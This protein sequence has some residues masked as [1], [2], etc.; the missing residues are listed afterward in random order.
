MRT[1]LA[2]VAVVLVLAAAVVG[3]DGLGGWLAVLAGGAVA[4]LAVVEEVARL[5]GWL[6]AL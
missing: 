4:G 6:T 3:Q 2:V 5:R 1:A